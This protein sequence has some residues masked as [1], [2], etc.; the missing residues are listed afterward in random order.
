MPTSLVNNN[1]LILPAEA[2]K[3]YITLS[4]TLENASFDTL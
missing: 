2:P 3:A 4:E 1:P